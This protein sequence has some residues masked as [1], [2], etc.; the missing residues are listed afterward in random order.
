MKFINILVLFSLLISQAVYA[1]VDPSNRFKFGDGTNSDKTIE[2]N[3]GSTTNPKLKYNSSTSKW[4]FTNDGTTFIDIATSSG[5]TN[6]SAQIVN[7]GLSPSVAGSALTIALKQS[8]GSSDPSLS[9]PIAI[10]FRSSSATSGA[11]N[12]RSVTGATSIVVPSGTTLG[13]SSGTSFYLYVYALDNAGTVE[14]AVSLSQFS[15]DSLQ[16]T[17]AISGGGSNI[18][19]Y[20]T[21]ARSS[22]PIR[23]IGRLN[24]VETTAG[25]WASLPTEVSMPIKANPQEVQSTSLLGFR[26]AIAELSTAGGSAV[27]TRQEGNWIAS[28]VHNS[29]GV[30]TATLNAGVF[31]ST[32]VCICNDTAAGNRVCGGDNSVTGATSFRITT[33][34]NGGTAI[35][36]SSQ[37]ICVGVKP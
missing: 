29:T 16:T 22:V 17:T 2:A 1:G 19:L 6:M 11:Y 7:L 26:V 21:T 33:S 15:T 25:T 30:L 8:D 5:S 14:L 13:T 24:I 28:A 36:S 18:T 32:P 27:V 4:Q 37:V 3:K 20:S 34:T 35:D 31:A 9:G 10:G 12:L 23:L